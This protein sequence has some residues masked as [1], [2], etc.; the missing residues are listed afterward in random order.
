VSQLPG[1]GNQR[2]IDV[3]ATGGGVFIGTIL[4]YLITK[5]PETSDYKPLLITLLPITTGIVAAAWAAIRNRMVRGS[6]DE[7]ISATALETKKILLDKLND[8]TLTDAERARVVQGISEINTFEIEA[9]V[10]RVRR[11]K[12]IIERRK[13]AGG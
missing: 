9:A 11:A 13:S 7:Y 10:V 5:I 6:E 1:P 8:R 12:E 2:R 3:E 4:S